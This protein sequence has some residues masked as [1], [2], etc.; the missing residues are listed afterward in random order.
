MSK[1][2]FFG[3]ANIVKNSDKSKYVY[4]DYGIAF[5]G[6]GSQSFGNDFAR[7]VVIFGVDNSSLC[8]ADIHKNWFLFLS[9][10]L[11]YD[12]NGISGPAEKKFSTIF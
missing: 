12:I 9:K 11:T 4:S 2:S 10:G 8:H 6:A 3:G 1:N 7:N 5:D